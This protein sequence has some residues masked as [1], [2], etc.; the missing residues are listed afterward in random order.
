METCNN[1]SKNGVVFSH[2]HEDQMYSQMADPNANIA[3][4]V[5]S[6]PN[7]S[8]ERLEGRPLIIDEAKSVM[9][10]ILSSTTRVK[11]DRINN[12]NKL[13]EAIRMSPM[14]ILLDATADESTYKFYQ[15]LAGGR[16][17]I[18][19]ENKA[20]KKERFTVHISDG[21]NS[22]GE[23][24][25][26]K[27]H[28][29]K[30]ILN[31]KGNIA[32]FSDSRR[33]C[34]AI[35]E[36]EQKRGRKTLLITSETVTEDEVKIALGN[37]NAYLRDNKIQTFIYSPSGESGI[38]IS[39]KKYFEA[40]YGLY[41]GVIPI[42]SCM[43]MLGRVRDTDVPRFISVPKTG[44]GESEDLFSI[45]VQNRIISNV[46]L[47]AAYTFEDSNIKEALQ[48]ILKNAIG[49]SIHW[50]FKYI[51]A[52]EADLA[53]E[54]KFFRELFLKRLEQLGMNVFTTMSAVDEEL[55]RVVKEEK[56]EAKLAY[57]TAIF[58]EEDI[59]EDDYKY[60]SAKYS[61]NIK[62]Q[63]Q[64][65][66]Y[67]L[68]LR[69]PDIEKTELWTAE[70]VKDLLIDNPQRISQLERLMDIE[71]PEFS[72]QKGKERWTGYLG[73]KELSLTDIKHNTAI[74]KTLEKVGVKKL[75]ESGQKFSDGHEGLEEL[76][77]KCSNPD[78]QK[79]FGL[80]PGKQ[81][82][83]RFFGLLIEKFF[84]LKLVRFRISSNG[85]QINQYMV[86]PLNET[87]Q[88][89][90]FECLMKKNLKVM[91]RADKLP[92]PLM[93]QEF[94]ASNENRKL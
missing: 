11:D 83:I 60:L 74:V 79:L 16:K 27:S 55:K 36:L 66:K 53:L 84:G 61:L 85:K 28:L 88:E 24:V 54:K 12:L 48:N 15:E 32:V 7:W 57:A 51:A 2:L 25:A 30:Q 18:T 1:R 89:I 93:V 5:D 72:V 17:V 87:Y 76:K 75:L 42:D 49:E 14:V 82:A 90:M 94:Q 10:H 22:K 81:S 92:E 80:K 44:I 19:Y 43:Q 26:D 20:S 63:R 39:I 68:K 58:N 38:D 33:E 29:V 35:N 46:I 91:E 65:K 41:Y 78:I 59:D 70:L 62:E 86:E 45:Q 47:D 4:C 56:E 71:I 40:V 31:S 8:V 73:K 69:L 67:A 23:A 52:F 50:S 9:I 3:F 37:L 64:V 6:L 13:K 34:E 77:K 21:I